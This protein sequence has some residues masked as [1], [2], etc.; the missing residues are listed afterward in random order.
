MNFLFFSFVKLL[1][2]LINKNRVI[3]NDLWWV[4]YSLCFLIFYIS[5]ELISG[6]DQEAAAVVMARQVSFKMET[7]VI[8]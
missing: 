8:C 5:Q 6:F 2:L 7:E 4:L 3:Y 1:L